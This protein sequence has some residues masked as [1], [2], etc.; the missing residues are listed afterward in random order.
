MAFTV[1]EALPS[2][3][4]RVMPGELE[5]NCVSPSPVPRG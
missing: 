1:P 2:H 5:M 3:D 4:G